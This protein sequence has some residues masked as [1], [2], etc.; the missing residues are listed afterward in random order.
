M[1]EAFVKCINVKKEYK[2]GDVTIQAVDDL[3]LIHI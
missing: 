1:N 3:S 2:T